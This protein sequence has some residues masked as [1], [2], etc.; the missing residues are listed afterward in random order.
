MYSTVSYQIYPR[1]FFASGATATMGNIRGI[2][3][4]LDHLS[5]LGVD[6]FWLSP[7]YPS[8]DYDQG[9]DVTDHTAVDPRLGDLRDIEELVEQAHQRGLQVL[10]D[11]IPNHVSIYHPWFQESL[12]PSSPRRKWFFWRARRD[13]GRPFNN[14]TSPLLPAA[15]GTPR[16][17]WIDDPSGRSDEQYLSLFFPEQADLDWSNPDVVDAQLDVMRFWLDRGVDGFRVDVAHTIGKPPG[18]PDHP[19]VIGDPRSDV[20]HSLHHPEIAN[21]YFAMMRNVCDAYGARTLLGEISNY[22]PSKQSELIGPGSLDTALIFS[23]QGVSWNAREINTAV[24]QTK[25]AF[26]DHGKIPTW[27]VGSHDVP[28]LSSRLGS[29]RRAL[30]LMLFVLGLPGTTLIYQGDELM[31][32]DLPMPAGHDGDW[33]GGSRAR[34]P[35]NSDREGGWPPA[36]EGGYWMPLT[37]GSNVCNASVQR[38][39]ASSPYALVKNA[40]RVRKQSRATNIRLLETGTHG[41]VSYQLDE[42]EFGVESRDHAAPTMYILNCSSEPFELQTERGR[43]VSTSNEPALIERAFEGTVPP[44]TIVALS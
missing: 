24:E 13:D 28:R 19:M 4:K 5:E 25:T 3:S 32:P 7:F 23:L 8:P 39:N 17:A 22:D 34:M 2:T 20:V 18:L 42:S 10:I 1:S 21:R 30:A 37:P 6:M 11:Y 44:E 35:W 41:V 31:V 26:L 27:M 40:V 29:E 9:Y 14:Y 36:G 43:S 33:R 15:D 16:S 12:D 38:D